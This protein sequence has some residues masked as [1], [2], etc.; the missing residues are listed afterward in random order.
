MTLI[1]C[2]LTF[3]NSTTH[4]VASAWPLTWGVTF[5]T[6]IHIVTL[7]NMM[8]LLLLLW[9]FRSALRL[10]FPHTMHVDMVPSW[11]IHPKFCASSFMSSLVVPTSSN[12]SIA[13]CRT[14]C[15]SII[16]ALRILF[17]TSSVLRRATMDGSWSPRGGHTWGSQ[18]SWSVRH[19]CS[20]W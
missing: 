4:G 15:I 17:S 2:G 16:L 1:S 12:I 5:Y 9:R 10:S 7:Y 20:P 18:S 14:C 6:K 11:E 3:H 13:S 19:T 8:T